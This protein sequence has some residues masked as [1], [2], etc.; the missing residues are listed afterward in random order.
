MGNSTAHIREFCFS[1]DFKH[2]HNLWKTAGKGIQLGF[3]DTPDEIK[4]KLTRDPDLFLIAE[5]SGE[6]VGTVL[7]GF[8]GRRGMIYH[9]AVKKSHR[10]SGIGS[11]LMKELEA[12]L[13]VKGCTRSYL[14]VTRDNSEA[15]S[16]YKTEGWEEMDLSAYGKDMD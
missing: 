7:G 10:K 11:T 8:D 14:L 4:K 13:K 1:K 12:R 2:V 3:S 5:A 15:I 16:F 9:L 6:I